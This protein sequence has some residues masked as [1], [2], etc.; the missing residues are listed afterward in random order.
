MGNR[1]KRGRE[2]RKP[3][4]VKDKGGVPPKPR[5]TPAPRPTSPSAPPPAP[6]TT[7]AA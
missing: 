2:V 5:W 3:K 6:P 7:P 1:D 4:K